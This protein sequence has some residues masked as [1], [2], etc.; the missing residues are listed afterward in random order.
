[1][2]LIT[3]N[4]SSGSALWS[5]SITHRT[6]ANVPSAPTESVSLSSGALTAGA[7][8]QLAENWG[9]TAGQ[10]QAE[11][12]RDTAESAR[13]GQKVLQ[14]TADMAEAAGKTNPALKKA[15][16][17]PGLGLIGTVA[18][19]ATAI[20]DMQDESSSKRFEGGLSAAKLTG[21]TAESAAKLA[22]TAGRKVADKLVR[23]IPFVG[24]GAD[25][26][27]GMNDIAEGHKVAGGLKVAGG[28]IQVVGAGMA[29]TGIGTLPGVA[30]GLAGDGLTWIGE[31]I[32]LLNGP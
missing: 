19:G 22:G 26:A 17:L 27:S 3:R 15:G 12:N 31:G 4:S 7:N 6:A 1:M 24:A 32:R 16:K 11:R 28:Y 23:F 13:A 10:Q 29:A 18:G 9:R 8:H 30:V 21:E 5:G 20:A 2:A 14:K 25:V